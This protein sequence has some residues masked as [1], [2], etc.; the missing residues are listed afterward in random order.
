MSKQTKPIKPAWSRDAM[1]AHDFSEH[2]GTDPYPVASSL[3]AGRNSAFSRA[4]RDE[5]SR[6][7]RNEQGEHSGLFRDLY[8]LRPMPPVAQKRSWRWR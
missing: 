5:H 8:G 2:A 7:Y 4:H 6:K 1:P 3:T